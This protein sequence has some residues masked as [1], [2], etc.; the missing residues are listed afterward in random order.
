M[1]KKLIIIIGILSVFIQCDTTEK[2]VEITHYKDSLKIEGSDHAT[3]YIDKGKKF[4]HPS[5]VIWL[6]DTEGKYMKTIFITQSY[7]SGI[8]GHAA[9]TDSTWDNK[10]GES[11]QLAALPYWT[12]KK[13]LINNKVLVPTKE[14]PFLDAYSGETPKSNFRFDSN[15]KS[16]KD[17]FRILI[18]VNQPWDW[19]NF[20]TNNK[21]PESKSYKH[22][23]QPSII[24]A[25]TINKTIKEYYLNPIGHG[26]PKGESGELFTNLTTLSS[27]KEI[28]KSVRIVIK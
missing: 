4:N 17:T 8:F 22:S 13:G 12:F 18:E 21:Y 5:F 26:D 27:A 9:L 14:H 23:A 16:E 11:I 1:K 28:F 15:L 3:I 19:N 6:E 2:S 7:A 25:V 24:Y 20:W 10:P